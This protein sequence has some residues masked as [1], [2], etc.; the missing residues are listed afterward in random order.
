[1]QSKWEGAHSTALRE[2]VDKGVTF[3]EIARLLNE[4]FGTA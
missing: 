1:M 2:L 3:S 4:R